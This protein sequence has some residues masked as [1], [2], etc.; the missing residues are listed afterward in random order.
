MGSSF[1]L[2]L[3]QKAAPAWPTQVA[4]HPGPE[5]GFRLF[6]FFRERE[7][8]EVFCFQRLAK[9]FVGAGSEKLKMRRSLPTMSRY[10]LTDEYYHRH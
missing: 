8:E 6:E 1:P 9:A 2:S 7:R 3:S 5:P 10:Y 4:D